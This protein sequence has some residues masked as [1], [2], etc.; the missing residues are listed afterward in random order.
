METVRPSA[1]IRWIG[2]SCVLWVLIASAAMMLTSCAGKPLAPTTVAA[3]EQSAT[4]TTQAADAYVV[5]ANPDAA[6]R[7]TIAKASNDLHAAVVS[8]EAAPANAPLDL[9]A[10]NAALAALAA[11]GVPVKAP[12]Q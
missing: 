12:A 8:L 3:V 7:A 1:V 10:F 9:T 2:Y 5:T 11:A 6:T 4:L